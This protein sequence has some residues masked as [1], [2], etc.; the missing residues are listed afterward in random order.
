MTTTQFLIALIPA[1]IFAF[2]GGAAYLLT[3]P[4][5]RKD[6]LHPGE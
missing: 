5:G 4:H 2:A 1:A 6:R 3:A